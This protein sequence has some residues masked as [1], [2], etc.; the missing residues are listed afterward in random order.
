MQSCITNSTS[1]AIYIVDN[2]LDYSL[3]DIYVFPLLCFVMMFGRSLV[4]L[5]IIIK[6]TDLMFLKMDISGCNKL[7]MY[8]ICKSSRHS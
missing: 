7:G 4:L 6:C 2:M 3:F 1:G 5:I 8:R